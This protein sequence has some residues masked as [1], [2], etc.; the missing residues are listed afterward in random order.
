MQ[1]LYV[2]LQGTPNLSL[3]GVVVNQRAKKVMSD[4]PG[5]VDFAIR[6][7]MFV[8]NLSNGPVLFFG[9]FKLHKDCYQFLLIKKGWPLAHYFRLLL[10]DCSLRHRHSEPPVQS[11]REIVHNIVF[12]SHRVTRTYVG[13]LLGSFLCSL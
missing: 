6:L 13:V 3:S 1:N 11:M 4:S 8:L 2:V 10:G 5:L 12:K 9:E 7:M